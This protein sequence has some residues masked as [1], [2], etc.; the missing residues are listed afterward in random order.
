[1]VAAV[2]EVRADRL[3]AAGPRWADAQG[4]RTDATTEGPVA[5]ISGRRAGGAGA[6]RSR[7]ERERA[8]RP[9]GAGESAASGGRGQALHGRGARRRPALR[10]YGGA[11][12][13]S[14]PYG[15]T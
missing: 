4:A 12:R 3:E 2:G 9:G 1:M 11:A 8:R 5:A 7:R 6:G 13:E 15:W 14:L 10:R